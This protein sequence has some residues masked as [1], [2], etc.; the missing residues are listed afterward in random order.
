M[1]NKEKIEDSIILDVKNRKFDITN[2]I[3][4]IILMIEKNL[5]KIGIKMKIILK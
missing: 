5:Q 3:E 2:K 1:E 4:K